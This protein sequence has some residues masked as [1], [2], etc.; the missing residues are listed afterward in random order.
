MARMPQKMLEANGNNVDDKGH[1]ESID[2][3]VAENWLIREEVLE[4]CKPAIEKYFDGHVS[5]CN[6]SFPT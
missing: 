5:P 4:I 2:L 3:S 1:H 6:R